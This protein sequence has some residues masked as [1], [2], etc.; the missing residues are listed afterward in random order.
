MNAN[1]ASMLKNLD[2]LVFTGFL[3]ILLVITLKLCHRYCY[4]VKKRQNEYNGTGQL[5]SIAYPFT[6]VLPEAHVFL[7]EVLLP[8]SV[9]LNVAPPSSFALPPP[10]YYEVVSTTNVLNTKL[11]EIKA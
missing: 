9:E 4:S 7:P 6:T 2:V 3:I 10:S 1:N 8:P 5:L 11:M